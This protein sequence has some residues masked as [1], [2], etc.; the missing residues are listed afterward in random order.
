MIPKKIAHL[1]LL[2]SIVSFNCV[3]QNIE[4]DV[5]LHLNTTTALAG[6]TI[7]YSAYVFSKNTGK[8]SPLSKILYVEL[9]NDKGKVA[10]QSKIFLQNGR[11]SGDIFI[12]STFETRS[13]QLIAYTRW[14]KNFDNYFESP[15]L[16]INPFKPLDAPQDSVSDWSMEYFTSNTGIVKGIKNPV[17]FSVKSKGQEAVNF[18]GK[19][20]DPDGNSI[21]EFEPTY[22]GYGRLEFE[23]KNSAKHQVV[24]EDSLGNFYFFDFPKIEE[25][26]S[27]LHIED[28]NVAV[29]LSARSSELDFEGVIVGLDKKGKIFEQAVVNNS[30]IPIPKRNIR[31]VLTSFILYDIKGNVIDDQL[32]YS[33]ISEN[34]E[35]IQSGNHV[36]KTRNNASM[37]FDV[38][39]GTYS[40]SVRQKLEWLADFRTTSIEFVELTSR[41]EDY[42]LQHEIINGL[43][44]EDAKLMNL[45]VGTLNSKSPNTDDTNNIEFLPEYRG[46]LIEGQASDLSGNPMP[47]TPIAFSNLGNN[48]LSFAV[49]DEMGHFILNA[50]PST[51]NVDAFLSV[52]N[53]SDYQLTF[54]NNFLEE[55]PRF[56]APQFSLDSLD[57]AKISKASINV[58]IENAYFNDQKEKAQ[59]IHVFP[60]SFNSFDFHYELDD[61]NRFKTLK[62]TFTEY[63]PPIASRTKKGEEVLKVRTGEYNPDFNELPLLLLDGI[64]VDTEDLMAFSPYRI[65]SIDIIAS[66]VYFGPMIF[67]GVV[68][69]KTFKGDLHE[70]QVDEA[71]L[72]FVLKGLEPKKEY[73]YPDYSNLENSRLPD[74]RVQLYWSPITTVTE[75]NLKIDFSTSDVTGEYEVRVE[76]FTGAGK[77]FSFIETIIIE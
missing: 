28:G 11:G 20:L 66:R 22:K 4:E 71:S 75:A 67:D 49:T 48:Q 59:N 65:K 52:I 57:I 74:R 27:L 18:Q 34:L 70:F 55:K 50:F 13:Y 43:D 32:Y 54:E 63:I 24:L 56:Y 61:Y 5:F 72:K 3:S 30:V 44:K 62:E 77:P 73:N 23:P 6:E 64:P 69:L 53:G 38:P 21:L 60:E 36:F 58:Q 19:I 68:S 25:T 8:P 14:M 1:V 39:K 10:H 15:V 40:V 29:Q 45:V 26:G 47:L 16:I 7:H 2:L 33:P 46:E 37:E 41:I 9:I 31:S 76:G 42:Y 17:L 51:N 12:T 35:K